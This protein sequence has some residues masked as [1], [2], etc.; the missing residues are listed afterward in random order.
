M[1]RLADLVKISWRVA[2]GWFIAEAS[3]VVAVVGSMVWLFLDPGPEPVVVGLVALAGLVGSGSQRSRRVSGFRQVDRE[4]FE[5]LL[6]LLPTDGVIS[7]LRDR[8]L[9]PSWPSEFLDPVHEFYH[10]WRDAEREFLDPELERLK[11]ELLEHCG[12][13]IGY[14]AIETFVVGDRRQG[15]PMEWEDT[16]L[17]RLNRVVG[18][19]IE[20]GDNVVASHQ[21]LIRLGRR[22]LLS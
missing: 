20:R 6:E 5:E 22:R 13:L 14:I 16:Q 12:E 17:D 8:G 1:S 18:G 7:V 21:A 19:L 2:R 4:L 15:I 3:A 10:R 11:V 9:P